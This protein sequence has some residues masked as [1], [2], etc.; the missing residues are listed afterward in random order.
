MLGQ[1]SYFRI[2]PLTFCFVKYHISKNPALV[3]SWQKALRDESSFSSIFHWRKARL[4]HHHITCWILEHTGTKWEWPSILSHLST[5]AKLILQY[6]SHRVTLR[7]HCHSCCQNSKT[8]ARHTQKRERESVC[9]YLKR[10]RFLHPVSSLVALYIYYIGR[11]GILYIYTELFYLVDWYL[12]RFILF[13]QSSELLDISYS[14][15]KVKL[16][17]I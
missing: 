17:L 16:S 6:G 15:E 10:A 8:V 13:L 9:V 3:L 7:I 14:L 12:N 5:V 2:L 11:Y 1:P 4:Q